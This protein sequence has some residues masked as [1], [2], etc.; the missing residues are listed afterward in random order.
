MIVNHV[1]TQ[2]A[3]YIDSWLYGTLTLLEVAL[4]CW[5]MRN[6]SKHMNGMNLATDVACL[7]WTRALK[8]GNTWNLQDFYCSATVGRK[9]HAHISKG[10]RTIWCL[11]TWD[12][13]VGKNV[14]LSRYRWYEGRGKKG[15]LLQRNVFYPRGNAPSITWGD[16]WHKP[17]AG[18]RPLRD[19]HG[20]T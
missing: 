17:A 20:S 15:E 19:R 9:R 3:F 10:K 12:G 6:K 5:T 13:R 14:F 7:I 16:A 8:C 11:V 18:Y 4:V 1:W 2:K